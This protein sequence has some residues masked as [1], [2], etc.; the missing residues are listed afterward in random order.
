M[1]PTHSSKGSQQQANGSNGA[2]TTSQNDTANGGIVLS[3]HQQ[4][5]L[6]DLRSV[7]ADI[8]DT[9]TAAITDLR[10]DIQAITGRV[11]AVEK[12]AALHSTAIRRNHQ[13]LDTH[14]R[15]LRDM[16]HHLEDLDN[17]SR[18]HNLCLMGLSENIDAKHL[19]AEVTSL[20]N[21]MLERPKV[22]PITMER[23]HRALRPK[24]K[25]ED[26]PR[27]VV[28]CIVDHQLKEELLRKACILAPLLYNGM[29]L[30]IFQDLPNITLQCRRES[31]PL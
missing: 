7:A 24:G 1:A 21:N 6:N 20:F 13:I 14:T 25:D 23:I 9:L 31:R 19:Q 3:P 27:D 28:C 30:R 8:K 4:P 12:T 2:A 17:R 10:I 29:E 22:T 11:Q 15:Q 5:S 18:R 26:P 16:N